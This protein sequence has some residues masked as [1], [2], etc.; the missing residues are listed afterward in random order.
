MRVNYAVAMYEDWGE[1]ER[2]LSAY[3]GSLVINILKQFTMSFDTK[4]RKCDWEL[5][6]YINQYG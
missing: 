5:K 6:E 1:E 4:N 2:N 3:Q